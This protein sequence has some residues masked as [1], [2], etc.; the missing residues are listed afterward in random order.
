M[1]LGR[2]RLYEVELLKSDRRSKFPG[3]YFFLN[4]ADVRRYFSPDHS[5][6]F[7]LLEGSQT[8]YIAM[9]RVVTKDDDISVT[10]SALSGPDIWIDDTIVSSFFCSDR[11]VGALRAFNVANKSLFFRCRVVAVN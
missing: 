8:S 5:D 7:E 2:T 1:T 11:L 6:R 9:L 3:R 4:I 10:P